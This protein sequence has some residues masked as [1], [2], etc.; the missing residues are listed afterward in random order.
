MLA[1]VKGVVK[2]VRW[3]T[4]RLNTLRYK[5]NYRCFSNDIFQPRKYSRL[6]IIFKTYW[7]HFVIPIAMRFTIEYSLLLLPNH[8]RYLVV[9]RSM[10]KSLSI[11]CN[12]KNTCL[13]DDTI[14]HVCG[15]SQIWEVIFWM[16]IVIYMVFFII[17]QT[18]PILM[19]K[20]KDALTV[21][22]SASI[23]MNKNCLAYIWSTYAWR[24]ETANTDKFVRMS[25]T[26]YG[27]SLVFR[28]AKGLVQHQGGH[29]ATEN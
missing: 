12:M 1:T 17:F 19:S 13:S 4:I 23:L 15:H 20:Y 10:C 24:S 6:F 7:Q 3:K 8:K 9:R 22:R 27:R 28:T 16:L 14:V 26:L 21:H 18:I 25:S 11:Q 5:Q 2:L 29:V